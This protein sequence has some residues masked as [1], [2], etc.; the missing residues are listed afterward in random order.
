MEGIATNKDDKLV[1]VVELSPCDL[2]IEQLVSLCT[3]LSE[4]RDLIESHQ[5]YYRIEPQNLVN[6]DCI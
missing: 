5:Q 4:L 3:K 2:I 1:Q 6:G